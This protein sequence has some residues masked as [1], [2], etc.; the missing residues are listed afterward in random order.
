VG[1]FINKYLLQ[2]GD[3]VLILEE[4]RLLTLSSQIMIRGPGPINCVIGIPNV[5]NIVTV[6]SYADNCVSTMKDI[7]VLPPIKYTWICFCIQHPLF[8]HLFWNVPGAYATQ[9]DFQ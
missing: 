7:S 8:F 1:W 6:R 5:S 2:K 3:W 9:T 4:D